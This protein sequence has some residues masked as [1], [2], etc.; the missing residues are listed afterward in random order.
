MIYGLV[1]VDYEDYL[2]E[3]DKVNA[4]KNVI[5]PTK[6][7]MTFFESFDV[8]VTFF[9]NV[10]EYMAYRDNGHEHF[11][12]YEK[13]I[14]DIVNRG[15]DIQLHFHPEWL[16]YEWD[17]N[18]WCDRSGI[19]YGVEKIN[20]E[21][22]KDDLMECVSILRGFS[23]DIFVY[24]GGGYQIEPLER[25]SKILSEL[26]IKIDSSIRVRT[27][28]LPYNAGNGILEVPIYYHGKFRWDMSSGPGN[29]N[30]IEKII[31]EYKNYKH[32]IFLVMMGHCKQ[33]VYYGKLKKMMNNLDSGLIKFITFK[34]IME[35]I[36]KGDTE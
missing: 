6:N 27:M 5:N 16:S 9:C 13:Q 11:S 30:I 23:N 12:L 15:H 18:K 3:I 28:P 34:D 10:P 29:V 14:K 8:P 2:K 32:D 20:L 31:S 1:T 26:G 36:D 33:H 25:N 7:I 17:G 22:Y 35:L 21:E 24:R 4:P 19:K